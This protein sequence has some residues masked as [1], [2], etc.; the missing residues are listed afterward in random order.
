[1]FLANLCFMTILS[2]SPALAGDVE[3]SSSEGF[4]SASDSTALNWN[5]EVVLAHPGRRPHPNPHRGHRRWMDGRRHGGHFGATARISFAHHQASP[6]LGGG[7]PLAIDSLALG[8]EVRAGARDSFSMSLL[9]EELSAGLEFGYRRYAAGDF[10]RGMFVGANVGEWGVGVPDVNVA[11]FGEGVVGVKYT[12][13]R[14]ITV[15]LGAGTGL[16]VFSDSSEMMFKGF[17]AVG[18][19]I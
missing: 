18:Q 3:G 13:R 9:A 8:I 12:D 19:S 10:D 17:I 16:F 15:E 14:G 2:A 4:S 7:A 11:M 1:M 6:S 5:D